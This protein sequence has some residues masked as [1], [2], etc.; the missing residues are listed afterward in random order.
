MACSSLNHN[1]VI[2][3]PT[4]ASEDFLW[5]NVERAPCKG[6][7]SHLFCR[8]YC[9]L[10]DRSPKIPTANDNYS[11]GL[12]VNHTTDIGW[13]FAKFSQTQRQSQDRVKYNSKT[14]MHVYNFRKRKIIFDQGSLSLLSMQL[15]I[16]V[17]AGY[18]LSCGIVVHKCESRWIYLP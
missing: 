6:Q 10:K 17:N 13:E 7:N 9:I 2:P 18:N 1:I 8:L 16:F 3:K 5:V 12:S 15:W 11:S 14:C 4:L